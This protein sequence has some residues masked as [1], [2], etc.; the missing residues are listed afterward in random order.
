MPPQGFPPHTLSALEELRPSH[1]NGLHSA[2]LCSYLFI[3]GISLKGRPDASWRLTFQ[4]CERRLGSVF[5]A[6]WN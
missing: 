5:V 3:F 4:S 2:L 6:L 1:I